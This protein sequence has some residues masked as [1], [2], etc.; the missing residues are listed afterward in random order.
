MKKST[1]LFVIALLGLATTALAQEPRAYKEGPV[2]D[3]SYIKV[4]PGKFEDYMR[5]LAGP[6]RDQLEANKKAGLVT[7]YAIYG[8]RARNPQDPDLYLTVTYPNWG[9]LDRVEEAL[10]VAAR[11]AGSMATRDRAYADRGTMREVL[12]GNVVQELILK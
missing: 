2:V 11:V 5:Y 4:K 7:S 9:A 1:L 3:I 6:Y 10:A 8:N 12:G